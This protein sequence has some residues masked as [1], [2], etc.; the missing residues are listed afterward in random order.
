MIDFI[1]GKELVDLVKV[2]NFEGKEIE[3]SKRKEQIYDEKVT[4]M[5]EEVKADE[6]IDILI[7]VFST[8]KIKL[9][10]IN[11]LNHGNEDMQIEI[12][13][14]EN[15]IEVDWVDELNFIGIEKILEDISM[16]GIKEFIPTRL[17]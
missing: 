10:G 13:N 1:I 8:I 6:E 4:I 5:E 16:S 2:E 12:C 17:D 15:E 9:V 11:S 3:K 14:I 7:F